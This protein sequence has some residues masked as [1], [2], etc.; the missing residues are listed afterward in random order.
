MLNAA[1]AAL[2]REAAPQVTALFAHDWWLY[3][4]ISGVGGQ[5][6]H[7][8]GPPVVL[9]RQHAGNMIGAGR[10]LAAQVGR[11]RAVLRGALAARLD[12]NAAALAPVRDRL[13]APN[14][15]L[16]KGFETARRKRGLARL[17]AL[18]QLGLY[19]QRAAGTAGFFGAAAL[20]LV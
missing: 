4:L 17:R 2:A 9:Y 3:Q 16:F 5:V 18:A 15:A 20:G 1:A 14:A 12:L 7:D 13:T 6:I 10:G 8:D 11:K 19:R